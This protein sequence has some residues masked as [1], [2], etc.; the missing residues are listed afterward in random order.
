MK[1]VL[2]GSALTACLLLAG[3]GQS[4]AATNQDGGLEGY[5]MFIRDN[6]VQRDRLNK[7]GLLTIEEW[8]QMQKGNRLEEI[9]PLPQVQSTSQEDEVLKRAVRQLKEENGLRELV[10]MYRNALYQR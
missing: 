3:A 1:K 10:N 4:F 2:I 8:Y 9:S 6:L 7:E 5:S